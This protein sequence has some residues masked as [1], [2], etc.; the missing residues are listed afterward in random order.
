MAEFLD[1]IEVP[2]V[3][4]GS[5]LTTLYTNRAAARL[6]P[7]ALEKTRGR[8]MGELIECP[9]A[10]LPEGCGRTIHCSGCTILRM[11]AD[12]QRDGIA[13]QA[14]DVTKP[15]RRNGAPEI[16]RYCLSTQKVG[17]SVL[18][19]IEDRQALD[20][21]ALLGVEPQGP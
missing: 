12:T 9:H 3:V 16:V 4:F 13:R 8:P 20:S 10:R 11:L 14:F 2:V 21:A 17:E 5:D 7:A 1:Q 15:V 19:I 6:S 18:L